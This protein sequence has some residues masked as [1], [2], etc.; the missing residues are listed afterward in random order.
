[1]DNP[2]LKYSIS[3]GCNCTQGREPN[4]KAGED[5]YYNNYHLMNL[6]PVG[7][8]EIDFWR[9]VFVNNSTDG[10]IKTE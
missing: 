9:E 2:I 10:C 4:C 7:K 8:R 3:K 6:L 5:C 1:M